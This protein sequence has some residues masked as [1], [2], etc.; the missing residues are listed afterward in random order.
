MAT[1][2]I[3]S[4]FWRDCSTLL[5]QARSGTSSGRRR[6]RRRCVV[7]QIFEKDGSDVS[8]PTLGPWTWATDGPACVAIGGEGAGSE[9]R[10]PFTYEGVVYKG[11]AY[12]PGY[13]IPTFEKKLIPDH[14]FKG[15]NST[16]A[17][18]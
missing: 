3:V 12:K 10:F 15:F 8:H 1:V 11:C 17:S 5:R 9:C 2:G 18:W 16:G 7:C 4:E 14:L 6:K 13:V